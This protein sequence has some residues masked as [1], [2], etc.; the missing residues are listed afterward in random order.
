MRIVIGAELTAI[1]PNART[2]APALLTT[3]TAGTH[4]RLRCLLLARQH[5]VSST[6]TPWLVRRT[7]TYHQVVN[8]PDGATRRLLALSE[9]TE[10]AAQLVGRGISSINQRGATDVDPSAT[11]QLLSQ[12]IERL[13]KLTVMFQH[14]RTFGAWPDDVKQY[15]HNVSQLAKRVL[16]AA[17]QDEQFGSR[18]AG[19]ADI[20]FAQSDPTLQLLLNAF[21]KFGT[22]GRYHHLDVATGKQVPPEDSP[23]NV[24][25]EIESSVYSNDSKLLSRLI[26]FDSNINQ[27]ALDEMNARTTAVVQRYIRFI[28]RVW[29]WSPSGDAAKPFSTVLSNWLMLNDD[30]LRQ[31]RSR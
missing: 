28:V 17:T 8:G 22:K 31:P 29:A 10:S 4:R 2:P 13:L 12:G 15:G 23:R 26:S 24:W 21:A 14:H 6:D 3:S 5:L 19:R 9:E 11:L 25:D 27:S 18:P 16:D 7:L 30:Q 1:A 20:Q